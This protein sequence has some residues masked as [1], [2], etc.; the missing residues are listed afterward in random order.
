MLQGIYILTFFPNTFNRCLILS[1]VKQLLKIALFSG[2]F[3]NYLPSLW[4]LE[5]MSA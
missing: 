1:I 2:I 5:I 4:K 3:F